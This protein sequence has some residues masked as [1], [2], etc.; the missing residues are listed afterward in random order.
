MKRRVIKTVL[1]CGLCFVLFLSGFSINVSGDLDSVDLASASANIDAYLKDNKTKIAVDVKPIDNNRN[2]MVWT[3]IWGNYG[4][5]WFLIK[6]YGNAEDKHSFTWDLKNIASNNESYWNKETLK[7]THLFKIYVRY[8]PADEDNPGELYKRFYLGDNKQDVQLTTNNELNKEYGPVSYDFPVVVTCGDEV[9]LYLEAEEKSEKYSIKITED[10]SN[11]Y[12]VTSDGTDGG[13]YIWIPEKTGT[14]YIS[15]YDSKGN[16]VL[17]RKVHVNSSNGEYLQLDN[18]SIETENNVVYVRLKVANT[19]PSDFYGNVENQLKFV[20]SEPYVWSKTIKNY[21]DAVTYNPDEDTYEINEEDENFT[22][23]SG[24]YSVTASIKSPHSIEPEDIISKTYS[25]NTANIDKF[26][27]TY[28]V[29]NGN[30][31][32]NGYY[33][34]TGNEPLEF[35]FKVSEGQEGCEYAFFILDARGKR[36]VKEYSDDKEFSWR[37]ADPGKYRIYARIRQKGTNTNLPNSYEKEVY[38]EIWVRM[39]GYRSVQINEVEI[40]GN[41]WE[42][43]D[44]KVELIETGQ[45]IKAHALNIINIDAITKQGNDN[46]SLMYKVV[47]KMKGYLSPI[48][49]YTFSNHIVI[50]HSF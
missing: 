47:Y 46:S 26:E 41:V 15:V 42:V 19:R 24:I 36:M 50:R 37:P 10:N 49:P 3:Q 48:S 44:G 38:T 32:G 1:S 18:I 9:E 16:L 4:K 39:G 43:K 27:M 35:V 21:G 23:G 29:K 45:S 33:H 8:K 17:Q 28:E 22:F 30:K 2:T 13:T 5:G 14:F 40:N 31:D 34:Q 11:E 12:T 7:D 6:D 20:I 25:K